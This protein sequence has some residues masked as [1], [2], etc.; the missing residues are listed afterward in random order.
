MK[1]HFRVNFSVCNE[2]LR[3]LKE[4]DIWDEFCEIFVKFFVFLLK[5]WEDVKIF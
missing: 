2:F 5:L 4:V 1:F 3:K